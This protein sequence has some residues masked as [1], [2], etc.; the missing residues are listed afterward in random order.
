[1]LFTAGTPAGI[2]TNSELTSNLAGR[3]RWGR[4]LACSPSSNRRR[5]VDR[6]RGQPEPRTA[7]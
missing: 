2:I 5:D 1:M 4:V 3:R 7:I 6:Q